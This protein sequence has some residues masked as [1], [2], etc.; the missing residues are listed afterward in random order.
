MS[1]KLRNT[2][3]CRDLQRVNELQANRIQQLEQMVATS[4]FITAPS[5]P[6]TQPFY[7][8]QGGLQVMRPSPEPEVYV[9]PSWNQFNPVF[10]PSP[11]YNSSAGSSSESRLQSHVR[12]ESEMDLHMSMSG[13]DLDAVFASRGDE[14]VM[15]W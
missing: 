15:R 4:N 3:D 9:Q 7:E 13:M 14:P 6:Q 1:A 2:A 8:P 5:L 11:D 12:Q 10:E